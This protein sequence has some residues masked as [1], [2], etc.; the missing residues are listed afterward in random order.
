MCDKPL[1]HILV[2]SEWFPHSGRWIKMHRFI[3]DYLQERSTRNLL[4]CHIAQTKPHTRLSHPEVSTR[5]SE[6]SPKRRVTFHLSFLPLSSPPESQKF[7][8]RNPIQLSSSFI[9]DL[10]LSHPSARTPLCEN[11]TLLFQPRIGPV[12]V[13][14]P[15]STIEGVSSPPFSLFFFLSDFNPVGSTRHHLPVATI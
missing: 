6:P 15:S 1:F 8:R 3:C 11:R 7:D 4:V 9:K 2:D 10:D 13:F 12:S 14:H 5:L